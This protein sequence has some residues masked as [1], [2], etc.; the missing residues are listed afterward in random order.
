MTVPQ[1]SKNQPLMHGPVGIALVH[2][3]GVIIGAFRVIGERDDRRHE[4]LFGR[5]PAAGQRIGE[6]DFPAFFDGKKAGIQM[7]LE[8]TAV[9]ADLRRESTARTQF[10]F[11]DLAA[12]RFRYPP[13]L[14]AGW[15]G[16][17]IPDTRSRRLD[18]AGNR[19]IE[20]GIG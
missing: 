11:N 6:D 3:M 5:T 20:F 12:G 17:G 18:N 10:H 16:P 2:D 19:Q 13:L 15:I 9:F 4:G 1:P 14:E 8:R 7:R